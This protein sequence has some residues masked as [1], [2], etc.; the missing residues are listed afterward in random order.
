[1]FIVESDGRVGGLVLFYQSLNKIVLNYASPHFIDIMFMHVDSVLWQFRGFYGYP[2]WADRKSSWDDIRNL[3]SKGD[4]PWVVMG[5]FNEILY[6]SEK[7]GGNARPNVMMRDFCECLIDCGLGHL[8]YIGDPFTWSRGETRE[9]LDRAVCNIGWAS[10]FPRAAVISEEHVHSD[11]HPL[12]LDMDYLDDNIFRC[13]E[14]R[15]KQFEARWLKEETIVEIVISSW[16]KAKLAG[17]GPSLADRTRVVQ[18]D[19]HSRDCDILK[20]PK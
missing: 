19:L 16:E 10:K 12:V 17:V 15:V 11:H 14:R 20:G 1:M 3:H 6:P 18:A 7:E 4:H 9:C 5:D 13:P 2:N 8:G